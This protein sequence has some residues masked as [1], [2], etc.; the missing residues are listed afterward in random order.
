M[1]VE[2]VIIGVTTRPHGAK[3]R[4]RAMAKADNR[5]HLVRDDEVA[6]IG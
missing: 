2:P 6:V 4:V 3:R 5:R 1:S